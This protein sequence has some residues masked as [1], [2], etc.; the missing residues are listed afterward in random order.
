MNRFIKSSTTVNIFYILS[1][2][3]VLYCHITIYNTELM[4][5]VEDVERKRNR[6]F[7]RMIAMVS[8]GAVMACVGI[9]ASAYAIFPGKLEGGFITV[10][11]L[12]KQVFPL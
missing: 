3:N 4:E 6:L 5:G 10:P 7:R 9:S 8:I 2:S 11:M 12:S 1:N